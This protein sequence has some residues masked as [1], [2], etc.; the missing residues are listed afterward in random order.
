M[1]ATESGTDELVE[2]GADLVL[3]ERLGV[4]DGDVRLDDGLGL[5]AETACS[6]Q[7]T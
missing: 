6:L 4:G 3:I 7:P 2:D 5:G 1:S